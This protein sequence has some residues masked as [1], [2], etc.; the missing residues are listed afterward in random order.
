MLV[1]EHESETIAIADHVI[2][3]GPDGGRV[4]FE[5]SPAEAGTPRL[6]AWSAE[7]TENRITRTTAAIL[8]EV[9]FLLESSGFS[10]KPSELV[11]GALA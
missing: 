4:A 2:D 7:A 9:D 8:F 1:V 5:G 11:F 6:L 10:E 3:P